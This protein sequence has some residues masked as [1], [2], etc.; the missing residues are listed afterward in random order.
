MSH[1]LIR[2]LLL[3]DCEGYVSLVCCTN[4]KALLLFQYTYINGCSLFSCT[5]LTTNS[6]KLYSREYR[7]NKRL[8]PAHETGIAV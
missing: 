6:T 1:A 7:E 5:S 8:Y 2:V 3:V 4:A